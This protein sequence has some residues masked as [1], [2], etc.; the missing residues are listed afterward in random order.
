M[1]VYASVGQSVDYGSLYDF[2]NV[3]NPRGYLVFLLNFENEM[4]ESHLRTSGAVFIKQICSEIYPRDEIQTI[5][6]F[7]LP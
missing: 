3:Y 7:I 1:L 2:L 6:T 4:C 5:I